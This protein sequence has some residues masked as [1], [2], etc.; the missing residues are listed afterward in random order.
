M[1][2][3]C[4]ILTQLQSSVQ[5]RYNG[6]LNPLKPPMGLEILTLEKEQDSLSLSLVRARGERL[7]RHAQRTCN[8]HARGCIIEVDL[9]LVD[10]PDGTWAFIGRN[11][12]LDAPGHQGYTITTTPRWI[13]ESHDLQIGAVFAHELGHAV[14]GDLLLPSQLSRL[15]GVC[16]VAV[17]L[18]TS[19]L[20]LWQVSF[21]LRGQFPGNMWWYVVAALLLSH[22]LLESWIGWRSR[23]SE[24]K[25]DAYAARHGFAHGLVDDLAH[26][27]SQLSW[28][29]RLKSKSPSASHPTFQARAKA[30][31]EARR[32]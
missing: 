13:E 18:A 28:L 1:W 4:L 11:R 20:F 25:A 31:L 26:E 5:T 23:Q 19:L 3:S 30:L 6:A 14:H 7:L 8:P 12:A 2:R 24:F 16:V 32:E 29:D 17:S 21:S 10:D 27:W 22:I 15:A 9:D